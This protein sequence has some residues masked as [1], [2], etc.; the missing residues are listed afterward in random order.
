MMLSAALLAVLG[1]TA[2]AVDGLALHTARRSVHMTAQHG[3]SRR[4]F[5]GVAPALTAAT[6][7]AAVAKAVPVGE[8][9]LP[10]G[11]RQFDAVVRAQ[12]DWAAIGKRV[13]TGHEDMT[14][15]EWSNIGGYLRKLYAVGDDMKGIS[16]GFDPTKKAQAQALAKSFQENVKAADK[17]VKAA[18]WEGFLSLHRTAGGQIDTFLGLM[19]DIPDEL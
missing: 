2:T 12:R 7:G 15:D 9:G 4:F 10:E 14:K 13:A 6:A 5:F 11:A 3:V 19:Q 8:G 1:L 16:T 18:D 17:P